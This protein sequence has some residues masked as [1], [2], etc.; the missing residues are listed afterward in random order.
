MLYAKYIQLVEDHAVELTQKWVA[1]VKKNPATPSYKEMPDDLLYKR[2]YDVFRKL[3]IWILQN[4]PCDS[5]TA[6]HYLNLGRERAGENIK[7]SEVTYSLILSRVVLW[8]YVLNQGMINS[9]FDLQQAFEFFQKVNNFYDKA[10][11]LVSIGHESFGTLGKDE[12]KK[13]EFVEK[14]VRAVTR[15]LFR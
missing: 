10:I 5:E 4:D 1:E 2:I 8:R 9:F 11:Y 13:T 14:S 15:W 3:H 7:L 6:A 12:I